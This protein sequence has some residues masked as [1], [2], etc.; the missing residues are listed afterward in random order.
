MVKPQHWQ[1]SKKTFVPDA[2][3]DLGNIKRDS[4]L[5]PYDSRVEE[6]AWTA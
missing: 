6:Q 4:L 2:I 1:V 5:P 3:K